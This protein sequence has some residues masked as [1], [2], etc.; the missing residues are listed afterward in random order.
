[1][2]KFLAILMAMMML[3]SMMAV[4]AAEQTY[5]D[6]STATFKVKYTDEWGSQARPA[7]TFTYTVTAADEVK[8]NE[9]ATFP[10]QLPTI[11]DVTFAVTD[12]VAEKQATITLPEYTAVGIYEYTIKQNQGNTAGVTY[13]SNDILLRVTVI[14]QNGRIRVAAVHCEADKTDSNSKT[15]ETENVYKASS[16]KLT[17]TVTG[18]MG[19][20]N[21]YFGVTVTF[22]APAGT[23]PAANIAVSG[24]SE[25]PEGMVQPAEIRYGEATKVYLKHGDTLTFSNI[26]ENTTYEVVEDDYTDEGYAA[27]AYTYSDAENKKIDTEEADTVEITNMKG[28]NVDTGIELDDLPYIILLAVAAIGIVAMVMKKRFAADRD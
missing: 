15:D 3:C 4:A 25:L 16:L 21:K 8:E 23:T 9:A 20:K 24:G 7:Q 2:K 28:V 6:M 14:E 1:M 5:T 10:E 22:T 11:T 17:K 19:D 12:T 13:F 18:N 26:A 27:A